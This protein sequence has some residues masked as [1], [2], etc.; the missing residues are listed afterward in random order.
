[1]TL[2]TRALVAG[3]LTF[4]RFAYHM[5]VRG[6][7]NLPRHG[8][9]IVGSNEISAV[10]VVGVAA[11]YGRGVLAGRMPA[12]VSFIDEFYGALFWG[13]VWGGNSHPTLPQGRGRSASALLSGLQALQQGHVL[14][15]NPEGE[16]TWDGRLAPFHTGV[17]WLALRSGAPFVGV[18]ATR[19]AYEIQPRWATH[20]RLTG[21]YEVR[22]GAPLRL[23]DAPLPR[24]ANDQLAA[25]NLRLREYMSALI[26]T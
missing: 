11:I 26:Y 17:A 5:H 23:A 21:R 16:M 6:E 8:P 19:G 12:P 24:V 22:V 2:L 14:I 9:C 10:G 7:E 25:A 4:H 13:R 18:V 1:M 15:A 3:V 20:P